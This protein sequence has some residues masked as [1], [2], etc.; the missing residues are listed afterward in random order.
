MIADRNLIR[1]ASTALDGEIGIESALMSW[2]S[3][4]LR[5]I[6]LWW[7][8]TRAEDRVEISWARGWSMRSS[9]ASN[10]GGVPGLKNLLTGSDTLS[11]VGWGDGYGMCGH[12]L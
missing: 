10:G 3:F 4:P 6:S 1:S 7:R 12:V 2:A 9:P 8:E 5:M 11:C